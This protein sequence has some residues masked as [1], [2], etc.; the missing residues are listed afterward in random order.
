[1]LFHPLINRLA[2]IPLTYLVK[3]ADEQRFSE[4]TACFCPF[5][6][7][8]RTGNGVGEIEKQNEG[9]SETPHFIIYNNERG[10]LYNGVGIDNNKQADFGAV[11]WMCTKTGRKGYGAIELYAAIHKIPLYGAGLLKACRGLVEKV[12]GNG[13]DVKAAFP[14]VFGRMDYRT[15]APQTLDAFSFMPKTDFNPQELTALGCEVTQ[16]N[17]QICYSFG[18]DFNPA[19]I[20]RIFRIYS[21]DRITLPKVIRN[22][23]EVSEVIYGTPWN[24]LFVCLTQDIDKV[25]LQNAC[26][27]I[28]RPAMKDFAPIVFSMTE[29]HS[30]RKVSKWLMGDHVFNYAT[31][32]YVKGNTAV[33]EAIHTLCPEEKYQE[34][35]E[36]WVPKLDKNGE[37]KDTFEK[38]DT[39]I[40]DKDIKARNIVFCRTPEDAIAT[41]FTLRDFRNRMDWN[42]QIAEQCWYHVAFALGRRNYWYIEHGEWK[43]D[44]ID[45]SAVHY[46][47]LSRFADRVILLFPNDI[48]SQ[49]ECGAIA[50]KYSDLCYGM[51]P[52]KF[53]YKHCQRI[54]WLYGCAPRSV[55]D[56]CLAYRM[57]EKDDYFFEH[58]ITMPFYSSVKDAICTD[59]FDI[60]YPRDP[61]SGR[62]KPPTC[63]ISPSK[64]WLFMTSHGY[65]RMIDPQSTDKV[66][67][68]IHLDRCFVEY[69]DAAS[70]IPEVKARLLDFVAQSWNHTDKETTLMRD[71][72]NLVD[73]TF[74][75]KSASS[76]QSMVIQF[77]DSYSV[78]TEHFF[79]ENCCVR[80]TPDSISTL[81]Y[82]DVNFFVPSLARMEWDFT[83]PK[84]SPFII[85]EN[86][87]YQSRLQEI[88][89]MERAKMEDG[90]PQYTIYEINRK[91]SE[92]EEWQ[93]TWRWQVDWFGKSERDLPP[94]VRIAL[95]CSNINWQIEEE[96]TRMKQPLTK[97]E[98]AIRDSHFANMLFAIGRLCYRSWEKMQ[99]VCPY[100][101]EDKIT[102][103]KQATGGS[104]KSTIVNMICGSSIN[105][106]NVDCKKF[107]NIE[108]AKFAL[109]DMQV[110]PGMYRAVHWEDWQKNFSLKFLYNMISTGTQYE[111][112]FGDPT[113]LKLEDSP[114]HIVTSNTPLSDSDESTVGRFP[115]VSFS[116]RFARANQ[117]TNKPARSPKDVMPGFNSLGVKHW[118]TADRNQAIYLCALAVQF[119]MKYQAVVVAPVENV[120]RRQMV[121]KLTENIVQYFEYFFG[122]KEVYGIPVCTRDMFN[123]FMRDWADASEA[124]S[125]E[126]SPQT[127]KNKIRIWC[128][129]NGITYNPAHLL[130]G[131]AKQK[132]Y[133]KLR[134]W[135]TQEYFV[136]GPWEMDDTV[137]PK[138]IRHLAVSNHVFY[139]FR[140]KDKVPADYQS[141]LQEHR[142][143]CELPDPC[144]PLDADGRPFTLTDEE[145]S[146]WEDFVSRK[147]GKRWVASAA[148]TPEKKIIEVDVSEMPF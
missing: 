2:N 141:L 98:T 126:Y 134:A 49:R 120:R 113:T 144:P 4:Q 136:G 63:K 47:K 132:G 96:K 50:T 7:Q 1:M 72:A 77:S 21:V 95:G 64:V 27:C 129:N 34:T 73:K 22:G 75:E 123:E 68:Y 30:I 131:T 17:G 36:E 5:C 107:Q 6:R 133:F 80:I 93:Q 128:D 23:Q 104:G 3:P 103:E 57:D 85:R 79:F 56:Y 121:V 71:A 117:F 52:Q 115:I 109:T 48:N 90:S 66:G 11:K 70:V 13:D 106:L 143:F 29:E 99:P 76:L 119:V 102:D 88:E 51:L 20:N 92:L 69:I 54:Q 60:E 59:P 67:Q 19:D 42:A 62:P 32:H 116:D 137:H 94:V 44:P 146:R 10:G 65:Y 118:A 97:E 82:E 12:Y 45:F 40:D 105:I 28:F 147:Q 33:L 14:E 86:P 37:E 87:E 78:N 84:K 8:K 18:E 124:K 15:V 41:Y 100:L 16:R 74:T 125:K 122:R 139:F 26:G 38:I 35:K 61:R 91:R 138:F 127:F 112:K 81:R 101:L 24:P 39:A 108:A 31:E 46:R 130:E 25:N 110:H 111:K 142:K 145:K 135:V 114:I 83:L 140:A 53:R 89:L 43:C 148:P 58:D 55:R 9:G